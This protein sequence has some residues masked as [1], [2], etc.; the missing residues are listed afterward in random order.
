ME[1]CA[2]QAGEPP[3][4]TLT[5]SVLGSAGAASWPIGQDDA[6][7]LRSMTVLESARLDWQR[8]QADLQIA[9]ATLEQQVASSNPEPAAI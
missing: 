6:A 3:C 9:L 5:V 8:A 4:R 2:A 7:Q 1:D